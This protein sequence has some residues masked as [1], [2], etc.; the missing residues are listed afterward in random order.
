MVQRAVLKLKIH[1]KM[2]TGFEFEP[3]HLTP[4]EPNFFKDGIRDIGVA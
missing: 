3:Y 1:Q 4:T 2:I